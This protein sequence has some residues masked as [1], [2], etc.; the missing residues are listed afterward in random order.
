MDTGTES[1]A[2]LHA[3]QVGTK[4]RRVLIA[5]IP[6]L[7]ERLQQDLFDRFR[8]LSP[9]ASWRCRL[10]VQDCRREAALVGPGNARPPVAISYITRP[11]ENEIGARIHVLT[12]Q[13]L[14]RHVGGSPEDFPWLGQQLP[15]LDLGR[16][17]RVGRDKIF[18][19]P[20]S[21]IFGPRSVRRM[22][23]GLM[24]RWTM[25]AWCAT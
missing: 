23:P 8:K 21:R 18:A 17:R 20:K 2:T 22:F 16:A 3:Q 9:A 6:I 13:L 4:I 7:L 5:Q 25:P 15:R 10:M 24:S 14:G 1:V 12:A 19:S 11:S